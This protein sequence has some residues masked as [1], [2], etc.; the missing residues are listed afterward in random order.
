MI[1]EKTIDAAAE[2]IGSQ[3][4][5]AY[6][7]MLDDFKQKHPIVL[8]YLFSEGFSLL[9]D[10]ERELLLYIVLVIRKAYRKVHRH[11]PHPVSEQELGNAE[12]NNWATMEGVA[13]KE[14]RER[15]NVFFEGTTQEDLL[16]FVEDL[17]LDEE[18]EIVTRAAREYIFIAA[19]SVVDVWCD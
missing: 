13:A 10:S 8:A 7:K 18:E 5:A 11:E 6:H 12:E 16:A 9:T 4:G 2:S 17:L 3:D 19:K 1:P 14:F 15:L